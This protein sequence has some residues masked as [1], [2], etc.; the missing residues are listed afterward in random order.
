MASV[1]MGHHV[2]VMSADAVARQTIPYPNEG[3]TRIRRRIGRLFTRSALAR[4]I[5]ERLRE[6]P[7]QAKFLGVTKLFNAECHGFV[8][9]FGPGAIRAQEP[10]PPREVEAEV[11]VGLTPND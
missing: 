10:V 1:E 8:T 4:I 5:T 9:G 11:A 6:H 7:V 3:S 2:A